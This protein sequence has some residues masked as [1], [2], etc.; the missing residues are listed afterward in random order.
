MRVANQTIYGMVKQNLAN[1]AEDL[2]KANKVVSTG[3]RIT[4]LSDDP[5]GLTQALHIKA[6]L[7]NWLTK[8]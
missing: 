7:S 4:D 1:I 5:V 2:V 3:K 8:S 6:N